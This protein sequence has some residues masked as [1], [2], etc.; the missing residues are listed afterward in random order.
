MPNGFHFGHTC[1][2]I[3]LEIASAKKSLGSLMVDLLQEQCPELAEGDRMRVAERWAV[4]AYAAVEDVFEETRYTNVDMRNAAERQIADMKAE[5]QGLEL[6]IDQ[7]KYRV[8]AYKS[9][10]AEMRAQP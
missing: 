1:P 6:Q 7:L 8:D 9:R 5:I 2:R 10:N 4:R 3:D